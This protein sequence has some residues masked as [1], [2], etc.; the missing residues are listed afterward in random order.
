MALKKFSSRCMRPGI[1]ETLSLMSARR[2]SPLSGICDN[3][4]DIAVVY[5]S[6]KIFLGVIDKALLNVRAFYRGLTRIVLTGI[7]RHFEQ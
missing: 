1:S 2:S 4:S 5:G 3:V 6:A 7:I